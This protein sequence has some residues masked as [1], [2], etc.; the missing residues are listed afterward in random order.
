MKDWVPPRALVMSWLGLLALLAVTV[1]T[2]YLPLGALNS[3]FALFIALVKALIVAAI[4]MELWQSTGL[5]IA[6]AA[7]GFFWL[8][9]MLWLAFADYVTRPPAS[10]T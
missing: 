8:G 3:V 4:F 2:A 9:I 10:L 6:F 1:I 7:A 5:T